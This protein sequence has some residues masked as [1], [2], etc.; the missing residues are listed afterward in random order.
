MTPGGDDVT[1]MAPIVGG[2]LAALSWGV[3]DY[4]ARDVSRAMGPFRA[5][6]WSQL[7]GFA[8]L[9]IPCVVAVVADGVTFRQLQSASLMSWAYV[10]L[11]SVLTAVGVL[12]F[13]EAFGSGKLVV[14]API[15]GGYGAVTVGWEILFGMRPTPWRWAGL[16]LV[17]V[18]AVLASIPPPG[19]GTEG[20]R[21]GSIFAVIAASLFGTG[22][23]VL[24]RFVVPD[25]GSLVP[26][27]IARLGGP[28][29][30]LGVGAVFSVSMARPPSA[31]WRLVIITGAL[32]AIATVAT[33]WGSVGGHSAVVAV[34]GSL[35]VVVTVLI[36]L[37]RLRERVAIHQWCGAA[38]A[39]VGILL[40]A[41]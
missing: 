31:S 14:V 8:V 6:L 16:A 18:G 21:R 17:V 10:A 41:G 29:V 34:L 7:A 27:A 13:F 3:S 23:F 5:Q 19:E 2:M 30:L 36:G 28:L 22:F 24:G 38:L 39:F 25:L 20:D 12:A 11:Y 15:I 35:S 40:L 37:V 9:A 1:A 33:G 32:A 4:L 26:A